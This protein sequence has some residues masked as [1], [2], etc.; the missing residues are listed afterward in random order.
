M[1]T[2]NSFLNG[3]NIY[4]PLTLS[5]LLLNSSYFNVSVVEPSDLWVYLFS[6]PGGFWR[7]YGASLT[8]DPCT[9]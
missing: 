4:L 2:Q 9:S 6:M 5:G 8:A 3:Q 1:A 7:F